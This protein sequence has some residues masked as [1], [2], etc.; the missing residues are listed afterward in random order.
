MSSWGRHLDEQSLRQETRVHQE[1]LLMILRSIA[2][3]REIEDE[4][5]MTRKDY[6]LIA[7]GI[8]RSGLTRLDKQIVAEDLGRTLHADN[9]HF[10]RAKFIQACTHENRNHAT[11]TASTHNGPDGPALV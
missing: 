2:S 5:P 8:A 11:G 7:E 1:V 3:K 6:T 10:D 9:P 4:K